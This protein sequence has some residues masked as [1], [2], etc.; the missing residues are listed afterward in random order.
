MAKL[1]RENKRI[2]PLKGISLFFLFL[3]TV[4][5]LVMTI[6]LA[7]SKQSFDIRPKAA[8]S[9]EYPI[10]SLGEILTLAKKIGKSGVFS[11]EIP[12][13]VYNSAYKLAVQEYIR[14]SG[15]EMIGEPIETQ[16]IG[17]NNIKGTFAYGPPLERKYVE[18]Y[19][20]LY[21]EK[22]Q[23]RGKVTSM[24][25]GGR[26]ASAAEQGTIQNIMDKVLNYLWQLYYK[27]VTPLSIKNDRDFLYLTVK[28]ISLPSGL[29]L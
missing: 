12:Q 17:D 10:S 18:Y 14:V 20:Y 28:V 29:R 27:Y 16:F 21:V 2:V 24:F 5:V 9:R 26:R 7:T 3:M 4:A 19:Y 6:Y 25:I 15:T 11:V 23:I 8:A 13:W 1:R 22:G